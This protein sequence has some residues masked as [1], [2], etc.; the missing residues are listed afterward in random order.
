MNSLAKRYLGK[1]TT[2]YEDVAGKGAKQVSFN[3]VPVEQA[4][5]YA[6]EDADITLQLHHRHCGR[7]W[8]MSPGCG[9]FIR[10]LKCR[11]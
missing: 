2:S 3:E 10:K 1:T 8:P 9:I 4:A 11:C 6:A 7:N 5:A